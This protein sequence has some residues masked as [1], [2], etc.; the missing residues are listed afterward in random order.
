[1]LHRAADIDKAH[2][3]VRAT[4]P[5][6]VVADKRINN[7]HACLGPIEAPISCS[8]LRLRSISASGGQMVLRMRDFDAHSPS[9]SG[10]KGFT[11]KATR[12]I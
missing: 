11:L 7:Q 10:V 4:L 1:M 2:R 5:L 12:C 6:P 8:E 3:K 9:R